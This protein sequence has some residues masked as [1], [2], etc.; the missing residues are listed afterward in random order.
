MHAVRAAA[1]SPPET[2]EAQL[3]IM[4]AMGPT[5]PKKQLRNPGRS[6]RLDIMFATYLIGKF[7]K[8][9]RNR[10]LP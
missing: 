2:Q 5:V 4:E 8:M 3:W 7:T 1:G 9:R 6:G 10:N